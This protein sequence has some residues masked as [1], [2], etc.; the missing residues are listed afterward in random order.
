[1]ALKVN[2]KI[3]ENSPGG[4]CTKKN[5][6]SLFGVKTRLLASDMTIF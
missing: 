6:G 1:M 3:S 2:M 4:P 5:F